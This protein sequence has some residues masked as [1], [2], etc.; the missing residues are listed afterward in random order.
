[1]FLKV[2][3]PKLLSEQ[4]LFLRR[5]IGRWPA[6]YLER[7]LS[8]NSRRSMSWYYVPSWKTLCIGRLKICFAQEWREVLW[9]LEHLFRD[10]IRWILLLLPDQLGCLL[11][12]T[13]GWEW[14]FENEERLAWIRSLMLPK[15]LLA[16]HLL[17]SSQRWRMCQHDEMG[18]YLKKERL[19]ASAL[20]WLWRSAA[21]LVSGSTSRLL[22]NLLCLVSRARVFWTLE[23]TLRSQWGI[24]V[25]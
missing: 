3:C 22:A 23:I 2:P 11:I 20:V 17:E 6:L 9:L 19:I 21:W 24:Y 16:L 7:G 14:C 15:A 4:V 12:K 1:M 10:H 5:N 13:Y 25:A 8:F 18:C